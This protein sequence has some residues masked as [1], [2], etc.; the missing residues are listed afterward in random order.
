[1]SDQYKALTRKYRPVHFEDIVSQQH[2]SSTLKNAIDGNRL[3][4]AYLFCGPRG[5]GKTTMAR[6]LART[7]NEVGAE[8]DGEALSQTLNILEVDAASNNKVEDAHR[9]RDAVRV[10]PQSGRYKIFIIDEV[11]ML[12]KA[13]FNALLKTL[14]EPPSYAIFIFATTEPHKVLP[15]ILSRVQRFDFKPISVPDIVERLRN[16]CA[17]ENIEIDEESLHMIS[18]KAEGA[19]RDALGMLDQVIA[20][21]G[22]TIRYEELMKAFNAVSMDR[23]FTLTTHI[24]KHDTV[25]GI[26]LVSDLLQEG[27]DIQEFLLALTEHFRNMLLAKDERNMYAI[28]TSKEVKKLLHEASQKFSEDDIMRMLHIVHEAQFKIRDAH[29]PRIL[30]EM[31]ILK[32]IKMERSSGLGQLFQEIKELKAALASGGVGTGGASTSGGNAKTGAGQTQSCTV[33]KPAHSTVAS[34]SADE[35][36]PYGN[37]ADDLKAKRNPP[38][39]IENGTSPQETSEQAPK[40]VFTPQHGSGLKRKP[41]MRNK[42][43]AISSESVTT[44]AAVTTE[45]QQPAKTETAADSNKPAANPADDTSASLPPENAIFEKAKASSANSKAVYLH[46]VKSVWDDYIKGLKEPIPSMVRLSME[47]VQPSELNGKILTL[48]SHDH[49]IAQMVEEHQAALSSSLETYIG[50]KLRIRCV[51]KQAGNEKKEEDPYTRFKKLQEKDPRIKT[52]VDVFGA[53]LEW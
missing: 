52:I 30:L 15:T 29:Q 47:S 49:F 28:E 21:C 44:K 50:H 41:G 17:E 40:P 38:A 46:S 51:V 33:S 34:M 12:S 1:M 27:H 2:V 35:D 3:S 25:A 19:L 14:E 53:E 6:V 5:V 39:G 20:L 9:I 45:T 13:A 10:P 37:K 32:L 4:H 26:R 18:R 48:I 8:V 7:I 22:T 24:E 43:A 36:S 42:M 11:H 23:L 16:I 31:T